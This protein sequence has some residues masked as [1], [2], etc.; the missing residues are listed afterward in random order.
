MNA[1]GLSIPKERC[2]KIAIRMRPGLELCGS[3]ILPR[4]CWRTVEPIY[5][6][7]AFGGEEDP[8]EIISLNASVHTQLPT[9]LAVWKNY[10]MIGAVWLDDPA[11]S[12]QPGKKFDVDAELAGE[13][14]LSNA[15]MET[16]TQEG[17]Q[18]C[19]Q[20]HDTRQQPQSGGNIVLPAKKINVSHI[21]VNAYLFGRQ[22]QHQSESTSPSRNRSAAAIC[23][24][25][26]ESSRH[27]SKNEP[28]IRSTAIRWHKPVER[29]LR[30][31]TALYNAVKPVFAH[32][33]PW[34]LARV[35]PQNLPAAAQAAWQAARQQFPNL[36]FLDE[37]GSGEEFMHFHRVMVRN[38]K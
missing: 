12:F 4:R 15:T 2:V 16:F 38:F 24:A 6:V 26:S 27:R 30:L 28:R 36:K 3:S 37:A 9:G 1:I 14:K 18:H 21:L 22:L 32:H 23:T 5:R 11:A 35:R 13:T 10:K 33:A 20:C 34:H 25:T 8:E 19:F 31:P 7:F 17:K 29:I